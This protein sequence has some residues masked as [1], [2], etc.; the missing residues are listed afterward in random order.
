M[1]KFVKFVNVL[2]VFFQTTKT[3]QILC[4]NFEIYIVVHVYLNRVY[5]TEAK[6]HVYNILEYMYN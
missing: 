1:R 6:L 3:N 4:H 5:I 2:P